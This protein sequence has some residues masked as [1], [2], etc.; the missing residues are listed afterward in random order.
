MISCLMWAIIFGLR[1]YDIGNDNASYID[2]FMGR[3]GFYGD[4]KNN[5]EIEPGFL[6]FTRIVR[7]ITD[8]Y[9]I[10]FSV[11]SCAL[12]YMLYKV[13]G[14][15]TT[16]KQG[17]TGM[18]AAMLIADLFVSLSYALRQSLAI[19]VLLLGLFLFFR[20][21]IM[22][23][24][25][26]STTRLNKIGIC[27]LVIMF[28]SPIFHKSMVLMLPLLVL[29][30]Y[31][32]MSRKTQLMLISGIAILSLFF[33]EYTSN[34]FTASAV[35]FGDL[36]LDFVRSDVMSIYADEFGENK[37]KIITYAAW[38]LPALLTTYLSKEEEVRTFA[39]NCFVLSICI[40]LMFGTSFLIFRINT[41]LILIGFTQWLPK[42]A[43]QKGKW[44][45][46]Y[47]VFVLA[48]LV[49]AIMR[50]NNWPDTDSTIPYYFFWE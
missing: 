23:M 3:G 41:V 6:I 1:R 7:F 18:M 26:N 11:V 4:I 25:S 10:Y 45:M 9:T 49:K 31:I 46:V 5:S 44:K 38:A 17:A 43:L 39:Y 20:S 28:S 50:F 13:Y 34:L 21:N 16:A 22:P 35:A 29:A 12:W 15:L 24:R 37:Q 30:Y 33:S 14:L 36:G 47:T 48:L 8:S 19:S 2:F 42:I 40:F 27:G 32:R